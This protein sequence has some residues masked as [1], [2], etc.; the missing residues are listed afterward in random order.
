MKPIIHRSLVSQ[1][2]WRIS[3]RL[4]S[5]HVVEIQKHHAHTRKLGTS[6][7]QPAH[8]VAIP[9]SISFPVALQLFDEMSDL[10]VISATHIIGHFAR[11]HRHEEAIYLFSKMLVSNITP[12]EFTFGTVT[13]S[14]TLLGNL[15]IGKQVHACAMKIGLHS[16]VYVG[17]ALLDFYAKLS[18]TE[19]AQRA[20]EDTFEPN[21]VSYTTLIS[22]YLKKER[23]E[24]AFSVFQEMPERNI[25]S[26][27]AMIGGCS[28]T[29]HNEEA[30]NLFV[31]MLR[32]G[33]LPDQSTFPCAISAAANI[34]ALGMGKSFH[35]CAIKCL[36]KLNVFVGNSL[37]SFYAKC[38]TMEDSLLVF[39]K[40][41]ERNIVSWNA[42]ICGYAQNGG[43]E[44]AIKFFERM[45]LVGCRPNSVTLL[46]ILWA[47]NH[48]GLVDEGYSYFN[49]AIVEDPSMLKPEHYACIVDLLSRS[50]HFRQ[51]EEFLWDLPFDPGIGFWKAL[52]GG[53]QIHS[54]VE[55]GQFA[56]QK[57]LTL[58]PEDV[59]S[60]VMLSN[61]HS[62]A[63]RWSCVSTIRREMKEKGMKRIPGSSWIEIRS[64]VHVFITGDRN[65]H[66]KD[67][68]YM[69]LRFCI[70][71]LRDLIEY[72]N[73]L[74]D[75]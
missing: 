41:S 7:V 32:N 68:I 24:D 3:L 72:S 27:N 11:Q 42:V 1:P 15:N 31:E 65:H 46:G 66:Q 21:V 61:A 51:A 10:G 60:Y 38:G 71:H 50:G 14:S 34:A 29:G 36:G 4:A 5:S 64:K 19:E 56:A 54:N 58:Y 20:F 74:E 75:S 70:E 2:I 57:I 8:T 40:V 9:E 30:V 52:L 22:S 62:A 44:E 35:A 26:W 25:V 67:E 6:G 12:N 69:A 18:T 59:S 48:A 73:F 49:K 39:H 17:S 28:Q 63:G 33:L 37:I 16:N 47:C 53:C 13:H 45:G 23:I 43:G 55:L